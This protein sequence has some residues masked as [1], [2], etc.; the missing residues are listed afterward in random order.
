MGAEV[1]HSRVLEE[2]T[3]R[4]LT[5]AAWNDELTPAFEIDEQ[6]Q[7][8]SDGKFVPIEVRVGIADEQWTELLAGDVQAGDQL[9]AQAR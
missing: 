6:L 9:V 8:A 1:P 2:W 4:D 3:E 7:F 5:A